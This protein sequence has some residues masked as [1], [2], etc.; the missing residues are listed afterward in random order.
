M[1]TLSFSL[2][3]AALA[4]GAAFAAT[5]YTTPVGYETLTNN[6][7]FNF[8]GV[9]LHQPTLAAGKLESFATTPNRVTDN[10][11]DLGALIVSGTYI[12]EIEDGS[13]IIQEVVSAT[14]TALNVAADLSGLTYP[15]SYSLRKA[16][17]L[18]SVFGNA[19]TGHKLDIGAAGPTGADQVWFWNGS[20]YNKYYFDAFGGPGFDQET[21]VNVDTNAVEN[22]STINLIYAD[23]VIITSANG[24]DVVVTGEVKTGPTELNLVTGF[25]FVGSVAPAGATLDTLF[26]D[27][28]A[29]TTASGLNIGAAGPTGADQVWIWT[30]SGFVKYFF[31]A[32]GGPGFDQETW[33]NVDTN[34]LVPATTTVPSG[35]I[36][37]AAS[38]GDVLSGVPSFYS[39]L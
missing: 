2:L 19:A 33:V 27:T 4:T 18:A 36:I 3:A 14:G 15:V 17:T 8:A 37:T 23:G 30:G 12:L 34:A 22:G 26:G 5:A 13:G 29:E 10:D 31:D 39:N 6:S 1:K 16:D 24:K 25:N 21:W 35:Y 32:F 20:G 11:L 28:A 7:G 38:P 9:R